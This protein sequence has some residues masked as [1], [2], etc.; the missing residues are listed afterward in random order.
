[1]LAVVFIYEQSENFYVNFCKE[2][3]MQQSIQSLD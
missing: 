2:K 3:K 1:M